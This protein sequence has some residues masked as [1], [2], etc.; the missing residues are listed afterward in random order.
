MDIIKILIVDDHPTV[1][2]GLHSLLS[3]HPDIQIVGE[4]EDGAAA[5]RLAETLAPD[6]VLLDIQMPGLDGIG[7][8]N[9]LRRI[10]PDARI[11]ALTA[12]EDENYVASALRAGAYAYLLKNTTD[13]SIVDT[14]RRVHRG[15]R[16]LSPSL[17]SGVL[18]EF[19]GLAQA[20]AVQESGLTDD[21]LKVLALIAKGET[22]EEVAQKLYL[23][24]R[25]VMRKVEEIL[26]KMRVKNRTQAVAEAI[27]R[28]L[29]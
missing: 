16:L 25:T 8:A 5:L 21:E 9:Q 11:I 22:N 28:G 27:K 19:E 18:R 4:A 14:V 20:R 17:M 7:V 26:S 29:I 6:I 15:E 3:S 23:S 2:R 1:R 12:F 10:A 13:E 24:E